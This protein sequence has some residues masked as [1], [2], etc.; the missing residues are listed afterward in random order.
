MRP[1]LPPCSAFAAKLL[2]ACPGSQAVYCRAGSIVNM[3]MSLSF[4]HDFKV[5]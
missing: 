4:Q 5:T 1:E 2:P 3:G